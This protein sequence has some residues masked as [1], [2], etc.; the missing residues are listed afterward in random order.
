[1]SFYCPHFD[2]P[3]DKCLRLRCLCVPGRRG[4]VLRGKVRFLID[5][6]ERVREREHAAP[7]ERGSYDR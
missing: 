6:D 4:C 3:S 2:Q 1:M 5:P 7:V